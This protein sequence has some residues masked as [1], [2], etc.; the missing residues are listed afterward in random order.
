L[1]NVIARSIVI[2]PYRPSSFILLSELGAHIDGYVGL[3]GETIVC[4][5]PANG[6]PDAA[7]RTVQ[8]AIV[9]AHAAL[10]MLR[11]GVT[12]RACC[13]LF[14]LTVVTY[15]RK[16]NTQVTTVIHG[17][18]EEFGVIPVKKLVSYQLKR[19]TFFVVVSDCIECVVLDMCWMVDDKYTWHDPNLAMIG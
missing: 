19:Y 15:A 9:A 17:I 8:A 4:G 14:A 7:A 2:V 5:A 1:Q 18:A 6:I 3:I 16:Q 10:H 12:V 11:P 13:V